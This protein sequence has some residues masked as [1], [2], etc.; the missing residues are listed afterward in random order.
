MNKFIGF[1]EKNFVPVA[2]K[3]GAQRHL[4]AIRDAFATIMPL[5]IA[6]SMAVLINN[7]NI[8]G[9]QDMMGGI[10]GETWKGFGGNMWWGTFAIMSLF[11]A[12]MVP[13]NLAKSYDLNPT[14]AA[15]L[16]FATYFTFV[17]QVNADAWGNIGWQYTNA[18]SLFAAIIIGVLVTEA[19]RLLSSTDALVIKMPE[20]VPPAV[21][22]AFAALLPSM[23]IL[24]VASLLQLTLF[25]ATSLFALIT[26]FI[27][28]PLLK[29]GNSMGAAVLI[30][31][32][33]HFFWFFGLHGSN[34]LEPIMQSFYVPAVADNAAALA[35]GLP[36]PYIV[37]KSF[38]DAFV[39]MGGSG[40]TI[41]LLLAFFVA[42]KLKHHRMMAGMGIAPGMFNINE[43]IIFGLPIVLN[44]IFFIPFIGTPVLL[45]IISYLA[46]SWGLVPATTIV[47][48]W[49][50]PPIIGGFLATNGS[51][52]GAVLSAVNLTISFFIYLPFVHM[53]NKQEQKKEEI[54]A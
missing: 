24:S 44:P 33:N 47:I 6:G 3:I 51:I 2:A 41:G 32:L 39:Y 37:T 11:I 12:F 42:S 43:P 13:Y 20:G 36:A 1:L 48:P 53:A 52:A 28:A 17:P 54:A 26:E 5:I 25:N 10:F 50:S 38:F 8:P 21:A 19:F 34:I 23:I 31:F 14:S 22:K 4:V 30:A 29:V 45:T 16:S 46:T 15:V 18:T 49:V 7:M 40:T 27:Q 35:A 9:Y